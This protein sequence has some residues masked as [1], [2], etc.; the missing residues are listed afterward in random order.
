MCH[1]LCVLTNF[2]VKDNT[3]AEIL[4]FQLNFKIKKKIQ[5]GMIFKII[6]IINIVNQFAHSK[7][8]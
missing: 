5:T 2:T 1:R 4:I 8:C 6:I 7:K 3:N